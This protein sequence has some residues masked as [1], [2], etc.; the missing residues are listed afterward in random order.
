MYWLVPTGT[1]PRP[2]LRD[3]AVLPASD[4]ETVYVGV[5]PVGWTEGPGL[6]WRVPAE[7]E[8]TD[9]DVLFVALRIAINTTPEPG[10]ARDNGTAPT[11]GP[12]PEATP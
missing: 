5:P 11:F 3:V 2:D 8:L 4:A 12:A 6:R 1:G 9:T 10:P 7:R